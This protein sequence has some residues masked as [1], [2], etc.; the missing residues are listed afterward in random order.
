MAVRRNSVGAVVSLVDLGVQ[1][2]KNRGS[3]EG[4]FECGAV[5]VGGRQRLSSVG[6]VMRT[7]CRCSGST[8]ATVFARAC[9]L[10]FKVAQ[11][12]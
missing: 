9:I 1:S 2:I 12:L 3:R 6:A 5:G 7:C 8:T 11:T 4:D 10:S